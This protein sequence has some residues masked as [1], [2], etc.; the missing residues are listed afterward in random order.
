[1]GWHLE[2]ISR[3]TSKAGKNTKAKTEFEFQNSCL[4]KKNLPQKLVNGTNYYNV[5][6]SFCLY[7]L[8]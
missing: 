3:F 6:D 5:D 2:E 4:R 8:S 7:S 1:M